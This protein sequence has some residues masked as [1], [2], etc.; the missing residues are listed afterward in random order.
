MLLR[1]ARSS[2]SKQFQN[3]LL[4]FFESHEYRLQPL[5]ILQVGRASAIA[6]N[7]LFKARRNAAFC[8]CCFGTQL[9]PSRIGHEDSPIVLSPAVLHLQD[10]SDHIAMLNAQQI[11]SA[12]YSSKAD[13]SKQEAK[14]SAQEEAAEGQAAQ[15]T[16]EGEAHPYAGFSREELSG[17]LLERD[18]AIASCQSQVSF[19]TI[20]S[21]RCIATCFHCSLFFG[22]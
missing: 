12:R 14:R 10:S 9:S 1:S 18:S 7:L 6:D 4:S 19:P 22:T 2:L 17:M 11:P 3:K 8:R 21:S 20:L 16:E 5:T 13:D 15:P